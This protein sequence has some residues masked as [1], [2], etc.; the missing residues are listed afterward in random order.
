MNELTITKLLIIDRQRLTIDIK[1]YYTDND[2]SD[3]ISFR[4][5]EQV[6]N[7]TK[8]SIVYGVKRNIRKDCNIILKNEVY[9]E[10]RNSTNFIK[11]LYE[12]LKYITSKRNK[13]SVGIDH[14]F[15]KLIRQEIGEHENLDASK[16]LIID[17]CFVMHKQNGNKII[18]INY[19]F[20]GK[21]EKLR[22]IYRYDNR[23][24]QSISKKFIEKHYAGNNIYDWYERYLPNR[25][26][27]DIENAISSKNVERNLKQELKT[28]KLEKFTDRIL[29]YHKMTN[30]IK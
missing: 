13:F 27:A 11:H 18:D 25:V 9:D 26:I 1:A 23:I 21:K 2:G 5:V 16:H 10:M 14:E 28:Y 3:S 7:L 24:V 6:K 12:S 4:I 19:T 29:R 17:E 30:I 20:K 15:D 8:K 22:V